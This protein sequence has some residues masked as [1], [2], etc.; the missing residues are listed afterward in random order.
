MGTRTEEATCVFQVRGQHG[1][2]TW[3]LFRHCLQKWCE[4]W[5]SEQHRLLAHSGH[6]DWDSWIC[7]RRFARGPKSGSRKGTTIS[8][9]YI[10][11][12]LSA[13]RLR[14][15]SSASSIRR[16]RGFWESMRLEVAVMAIDCLPACSIFA[17]S[18]LL[19]GKMIWKNQ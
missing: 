11:A 15:L 19:H 4:S 5:L 9:L 14:H 7:Q 8:A 17:F 1:D 6:P 18:M 10:R 2:P 16:P 3:P 12:R 13:L